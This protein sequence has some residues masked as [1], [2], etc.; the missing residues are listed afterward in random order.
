MRV[1]ISISFLL[2]P[3]LSFALP[4]DQ[5]QKGD[6][7]FVT[8]SGGDPAN[9]IVLEV[10]A[11]KNQT[12]LGLDRDAGEIE[13]VWFPLPKAKRGFKVLSQAVRPGSTITVVDIYSRKATTGKVIG[14]TIEVVQAQLMESA[15]KLELEGGG[16]T[17]IRVSLIDWRRFEEKL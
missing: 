3:I 8:D 13:E 12:L 17:K 5:V 10:D 4:L 16:T 7:V 1:I 11:S 6:I 2:L 15:I 14:A 9:G